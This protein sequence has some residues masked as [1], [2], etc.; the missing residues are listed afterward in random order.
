[1]ATT[2]SRSATHQ[3]GELTT[4]KELEVYDTSGIYT[5]NDS[6]IDLENGLEK[7]RDQWK[8]S[9]PAPASETS[10]ELLRQHPT[11]MGTRRHHHPGNDL[12]R[13]PRRFHS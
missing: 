4:G 9:E 5:E 10:P 11:G 3:T 13:S 8:K 6:K 12:H 2:A 1:M 7:L